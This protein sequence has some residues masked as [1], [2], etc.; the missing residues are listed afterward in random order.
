MPKLDIQFGLQKISINH[1]GM[2]T[3]QPQAITFCN[4]QRK[5]IDL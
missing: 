5:G 4:T 1:I 3:I 2:E